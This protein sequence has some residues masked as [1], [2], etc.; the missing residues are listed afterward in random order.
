M[1]NLKDDPLTSLFSNDS[2]ATDRKTLA[3]L[4]K[5]YWA[6]EKA[7]NEFQLLSAFHKID[8]NDT[9]IEVLLAGAKARSLLSSISDGLSPGEI[10]AL[11]VMPTGSAKTSLKKLF[12]NHKI[13][14]DKEGRYMLPSHRI[15]DLVKKLNPQSVKP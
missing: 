4:L 5:P 2:K 8:G 14:K 1:S 15:P 11:G 6:L 12:D 3:D 10:I 9:K 13:S 7:S